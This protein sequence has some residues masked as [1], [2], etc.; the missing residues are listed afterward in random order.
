MARGGTAA[1]RDRR[2]VARMDGGHRGDRGLP[3]SL[4]RLIRQADR[5]GVG[6]D[7]VVADGDPSGR[8]QI[9]DRVVGLC[10]GWIRP[11]VAPFLSNQDRATTDRAASSHVHPRVADEPGSL[12][13][14]IHF[15]GGL[16]DQTGRRFPAVACDGVLVDPLWQVRACIE[17][18]PRPSCLADD[19][20]EV[21]RDRV[22]LIDREETKGDAGLI[23]DDRDRPALVR[24]YPERL[25]RAAG[26]AD[27]EWVDVVRLVVDQGPVLVQEDGGGHR[28]APASWPLREVTRSGVAA[29]AGVDDL[30]TIEAASWSR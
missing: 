7:R 20:L 4:P 22:E 16:P 14:R 25:G 9:R 30:A 28:A 11:A 23:R 10:L 18:A 3:P 15:D 24:P 2:G 26:K 17:A 8:G 1:S 29:A 21:A 5:G 19:V 12:R 6:T 13:A 27:P